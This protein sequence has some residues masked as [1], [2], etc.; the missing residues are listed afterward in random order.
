MGSHPLFI[1]LKGISNT[2]DKL[3]L[4]RGYMMV[5]YMDRT[6]VLLRL[7]VSRMGLFMRMTLLVL[8]TMKSGDGLRIFVMIPACLMRA[9]Q[10]SMLFKE[11][12]EI[13][14]LS[15]PSLR[16]PSCLYISTK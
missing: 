8:S 2:E 4:G 6:T 10:D 11:S 7:N 13:A 14:G 16:W 5:H 1:Q 3:C 15:L 12:L 9:P